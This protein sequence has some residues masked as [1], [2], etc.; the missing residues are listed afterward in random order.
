MFLI[1]HH[2]GSFCMG[3]ILYSFFIDLLYT[4]S[5]SVGSTSPTNAIT[6][7]I[8][9]VRGYFRIYFDVIHF[10]ALVILCMFMNKWFRYALDT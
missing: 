8:G 6:A 2:P 4:F 7:E 1:H 5:A 10:R 3:H 9:Q